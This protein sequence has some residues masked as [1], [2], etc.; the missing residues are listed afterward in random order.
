MRDLAPDLALAFGPDCRT[1]ARFYVAFGR[2]HLGCEIRAAFVWGTSV[3]GSNLRSLGRA[4]GQLA[5]SLSPDR[6]SIA[7]DAA[8]C[9]DAGAL[10]N[11]GPRFE[12]KLVVAGLLGLG[13]RESLARVVSRTLPLRSR[14]ATIGSSPTPTHVDTC[15][16][17]H[18]SKERT[19][20]EPVAF[21]I[22][23]AAPAQ[24]WP[25]RCRRG[26]GTAHARP[27]CT[28]TSPPR[29]CMRRRASQQRAQRAPVA[30][31]TA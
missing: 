9:A 15:P 7:A 8:R 27:P 17:R 19:T 29:P 20:H 2:G 16:Q 24:L 28:G 31:P 1:G 21:V 4:G 5:A 10:V 13:A 18:V 23:V 12:F 26:R 25:A 6:L 3:L 14:T 30:A 11:G 22:A